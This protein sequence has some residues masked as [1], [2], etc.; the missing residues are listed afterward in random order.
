MQH[1]ASDCSSLTAVVVG[2]EHLGCGSALVTNSDGTRGVED[3]KAI[4]KVNDFREI[5]IN[6]F[7][8][9]LHDRL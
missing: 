9:S 7:E 6:G 5:T 8:E 2:G 4:G 1:M 3:L